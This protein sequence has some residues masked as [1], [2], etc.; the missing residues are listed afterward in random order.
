MEKVRA[1]LRKN[2]AATQAQLIMLLNPV[3]RGW[4]TYHRHVVAYATFTRV[5][6]LVWKLFWK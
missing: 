2:I 3:L 1:V 4:A 5:D 6:H